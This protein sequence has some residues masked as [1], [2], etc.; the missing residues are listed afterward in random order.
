M[1]N[2]KF[3]T[4]TVIRMSDVHSRAEQRQNR[5]RRLEVWELD[6]T[7][8][9]LSVDKQSDFSDTQPTSEWDLNCFDFC[10]DRSLKVY[11]VFEN[12]NKTP[13]K[14]LF[15]IYTEDDQTLNP[16]QSNQL[17][18]VDYLFINPFI[19]EVRNNYELTIV[20]MFDCS[21][22]HVLKLD[23]CKNH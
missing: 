9:D 14:I 4:N 13:Q 2:E 12:M 23:S 11:T 10:Q 3:Q 17:H 22:R 20:S 16:L 6:H 15:N 5:K 18:R 8:I 7:K 21:T 19:V 1:Y